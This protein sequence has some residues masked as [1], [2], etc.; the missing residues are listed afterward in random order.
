MTEFL[1]T[2]DIMAPLLLMLAL[3]WLLRRLGLMTDVVT[4]GLNKLIFKV[5]LPV[6]L[7]N[8]M[9]N[10]DVS[11]MPSMGYAAYIC[12]SILAVF[13]IV[14][15]VVS[16]LVKDVR[17]STVTAQALFRTN[18]AILGV[19]LMYSIFGQEG[20]ATVTLALP[21]VIPMY[22][23]LAVFALSPCSGKT[24]LSGTVKKIVT[25][26][27]IIGV[28]LG[29]VCLLLGDPLPP[30]LD[31]VADD[32]GSMSSPISL[33][34]L[35]ASLRW[36]GVKN[37]R[38]MICWT[39]LFKQLIIPLCVTGLA[40]LLGFRNMELGVI[41]I[42]FSAP[43]AVSSFPMAQA[44]GGDG[45]LAASYVALTTICSMGTLFLM[46]YLCKVFAFF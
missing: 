1:I 6:L 13:A 41:T 37:N 10:M 45:E 9:R 16:R 7:F 25:N 21:V 30:V 31:E 3:G 40:V 2:L 22:N 28:V 34:V 36:Q 11:A 29:A 8:N 43:T 24:N 18:F 39:L 23:I 26:P 4:Q 19:P 5:F 46:I 42:L 38:K 27:L 33:L 44:M 20:M 14:E 15:V 35:G 32:L 12:L 17:Q